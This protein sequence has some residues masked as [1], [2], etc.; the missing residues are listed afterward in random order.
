MD[1]A[2]FQ[3]AERMG[4][5]EDRERTKEIK[6]GLRDWYEVRLGD[7]APIPNFTFKSAATGSS[8]VGDIIAIKAKSKNGK[9][10]LAAI[11]ASV[12]LGAE[13]ANLTPT[14][15]AES[16][17]M[18]FDTEQNR[19]NTQALL[20]RIHIMCGWE[21]EHRQR[22]RVFS[23]REMPIFER[24]NYIA[25]KVKNFMPTA[26]F[27]DGLADLTIDFNDIE[28][29]QDIIL[30]ISQLATAQKC[31]I[32]FILHTNKSKTDNN[33]KG[34]LGTLAT[35]KCSDVFY[36]EKSEDGTTFNVTETDCRNIPISDF[37]FKIDEDGIPYHVPA[38]IAEVEQDDKGTSTTQE[39]ETDECVHG[40]KATKKKR[41]RPKK[42]T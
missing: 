10:F 39:A 33:M 16:K 14:M 25:K 5:I 29:S 32:F 18:F 8:P 12:I 40:I 42:R 4:R 20:E 3:Q 19:P 9:T 36:I 11:F 7:E 23:L 30:R 24:L 22:L 26:V 15:S 2:A 38:I 37:S 28:Q 21:E 17:V 34:H 6:S 13:F 1:S 27:I 35:Q 41:G 31:A